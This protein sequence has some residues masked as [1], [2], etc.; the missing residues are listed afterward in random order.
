MTAK[1]YLN[2]VRKADRQINV[3]HKELSYLALK[4]AQISPQTKAERVL[5]SSSTDPMKIVDKIVDLQT[6]INSEIDELVKLRAEVLNKINQL[7][8]ERY[9][10]V[11]TEYYINCETWEQVSKTLKYD[12][13]YV[14]KLHAKALNAFDKIGHRKTL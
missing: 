10:N 11:L 5:S 6:E 14:F 8:D 1:E 4:V 7:N 13:R 12:L 3:K 2:S 9:R